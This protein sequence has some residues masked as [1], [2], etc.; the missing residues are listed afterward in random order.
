MIEPIIHIGYPKT[1]TSW[2]QMEFFPKIKNIMVVNRQEIFRKIIEPEDLIINYAEIR[3]WI[4]RNYGGKVLLSAH[5]FIGTNHSFGIRNYLIR[6]NAT[7]LKNIFPEAKIIIFIRNQPDIIASTYLQYLKAGGTYSATK[8]LKTKRFYKLNDIVFFYYSYFEYH[9]IIE[10]YKSMFGKLN[11][12]VY[13]FEEFLNNPEHFIE[14]L[15]NDFNFIYD[16]STIDFSIINKRYRKQL[17]TLIK[18]RNLFTEKNIINKHHLIHIPAN[19]ELTRNIFGKLNKYKIFGKYPSA[20]EV[21]GKS[22]YDQI[23]EHYIESNKIL[24]ERHN[25]SKIINYNYPL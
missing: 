11:I 4:N 5:G 13:L 1:A 18:I 6:E 17:V 24:I 3:E 10:F 16:K 7:R 12:Y 8:F 21:L 2:L 22:N 19:F 14:I 23:Y 20:I 25:L 15:A 9:K